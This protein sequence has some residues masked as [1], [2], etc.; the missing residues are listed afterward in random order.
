MCRMS[1]GRRRGRRRRTFTFRVKSAHV[2][3]TSSTRACPPNIRCVPTSNATLVTSDANADSWSTIELTV[4]VY[5]KCRLVDIMRKSNNE[6]T[7]QR[8]HPAFDLNLNLLRQVPSSNRYGDH[9]NRLYSVRQRGAH[10][11]YLKWS[12]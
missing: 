7:F 5:A 9:I 2:P 6:D 4:P 12:K 11:I 3:C 10:P 1:N 8:R